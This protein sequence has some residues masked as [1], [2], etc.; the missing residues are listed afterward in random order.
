MQLAH[1]TQKKSRDKRVIRTHA[2]IRQAMHDLLLEVDYDD[3]TVTMLAKKAGIDR[4]TF[5]LHYNSVADVLDEAVRDYAD[6]IVSRVAPVSFAKTDEIDFSAFFIDLSVEIAQFVASN[7][8]LVGHFPPTL[9]LDVIETSLT[10][11]LIANESLDI[12]P[13]MSLSVDYCVS[14]VCAGVLAV[15]R[16]WMI[17]DFDIELTDLAN[18]VAAIV[19]NG[20]QSVRRTPES[21]SKS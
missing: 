13:A 14:F 4:K 2:A 21:E 5:Y 20:L 9:L 11:C 16:R 1:T 18:L 6:A 8:G 15:Y 17:T 3:L 7:R 12:D 10:D 19:S